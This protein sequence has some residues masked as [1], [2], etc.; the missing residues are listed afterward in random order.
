M[1]R[2]L[3]VLYPGKTVVDVNN[4]FGTFKN[5][6]SDILK[7]GTPYERG[8]ATDVWGFL[9]HILN[10][11][12]IIPDSN[13]ENETDSQYYDALEGLVG[14]RAVD[15]ETKD[16]IINVQSVATV[17]A[18]AKRISLLDS[19][20]IPK[21]LDDFDQTWTMPTDLESGV[22]EEA[23]TTYGLWVDS[24]LNLRLVGDI[25]SVTDGTTA[26][27]LVDSAAIFLTKLVHAGDIAYNLTT[28]QK[29]TVSVDATL[30]GEVS[31][32]D[33]IFVS[34]D[35]YKTVK[36]SPEGLGENRE[37]LGSAFNNSGSDFD[38]SHY[39]QIQENKSYSEADN[40]FTIGT[41]TPLFSEITVYQVNDWAG[42]G[43]WKI[44]GSAYG[45]ISTAARTGVTV[46][47]SGVISSNNQGIS[48]TSNGSAAYIQLAQFSNASGNMDIQHANISTSNYRFGFE[49]KV[50]KKP[51]FHL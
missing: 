11:A 5:R 38:D 24:D 19:D 44:A 15:F 25:E 6:T 41:I 45:T 42:K 49:S 3:E 10:K 37:R 43:S 34:G 18:D 28:K 1:A 47:I 31:V 39:T 12:G 16:L 14:R 48:A 26:G 30:E 21:Y 7:D 23:S 13:E 22:S 27:K 50:T 36:M 40:D 8:W 51:T 4:Q 9:A 17:D 32:V 2:K 33:D 20:Y 35:D 46:A 29:T